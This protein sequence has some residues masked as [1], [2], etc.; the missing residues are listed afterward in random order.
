[1]QQTTISNF[2]AFS[3]VTNKAYFMR[4]V[5]WQT[6]LMKYHTLFLLRIRKDVA[7]FVVCCSRD[8]QSWVKQFLKSRFNLD[9]GVCFHSVRK[10]HYMAEIFCSSKM[11]KEMNNDSELNWNIKSSFVFFN[12]LCWCYSELI[13]ECMLFFFL[14]KCLW[15]KYWVFSK[16]TYEPWHGI[17]NYVVCATSKASDQPAHMRRLIRAFAS[18]F[19]I[20]GVLSY[21]LN[22]IWSF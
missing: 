9:F 2:A 7:K 15:W 12:T 21:R 20:L 13:S 14:E 22:I 5:C 4:I 18:H 1:M 6:I 8:W 10:G 3:K 17:S 19:H 11:E 16:T